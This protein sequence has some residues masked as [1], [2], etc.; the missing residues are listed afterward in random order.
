MT[1]PEREMK[2]GRKGEEGA[3]RS[4]KSFSLGTFSHNICHLC[5]KCKQV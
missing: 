1:E 3:I 4:E 5:A 2:R